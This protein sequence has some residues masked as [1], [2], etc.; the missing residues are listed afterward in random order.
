MARRSRVLALLT[1]GYGAQGGIARYNQDLF[2]A[3][4]GSGAEV[5]IVPRHG[6]ARG[7]S[8]P[9]GVRQMAAIPGRLRYLLASLL[10]VWRHGPFDVVFCGHIYMVSLAWMAARLARARLWLQAHGVEVTETVVQG[11]ARRRA[12]E[13]ADLVTVVSRATRD[14]LLRWADLAPER[15]RVLPDTVRDAFVPG[16]PSAELRQR[17][18]LG[19]GPILLTVGRLASAERYKGHEQIFAALSALRRKFPTLV[20][21]VAGDGDDRAYLE[22][23]AAALVRDPDAVRFLGFVAEQELP[24]L[25]RLADLYVMPSTKEGFGIVY[26]EAAACGVRV[27]G[28]LGGGSADAIPPSIGERVDPADGTA[29]V[30]AIERLLAKGR[31][32][33]EAVAPYR[34]GQFSA[35]ASRLLSRLLAAPRRMKGTP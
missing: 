5:V 24:E 30:E 34:H 21:V 32:D 18:R 7:V 23:R 12:T 20:H 28:G 6:D 15:V 17:W 14:E 16:R 3:L 1:D 10:A 9:A 29:V 4:A 25:Y 19:P 2:D 33:A 27:L 26:L 8:L 35:A 31:V 11:G 13:A 22:A